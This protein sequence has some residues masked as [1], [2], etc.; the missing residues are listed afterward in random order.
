MKL[1]QLKNKGAKSA[2]TSPLS[3]P[4]ITMQN[5]IP[6]KEILQRKISL[7]KTVS[8]TKNPENINLK[9]FL[10][11]I[12]KPNSDKKI[13]QKRKKNIEQIRHLKSKGE[14]EK[15][16]ERKKLLPCACLSGTFKTR[17]QYQIIYYNGFIQIDVDDLADEDT[18]QQILEIIKSC[19]H[20]IVVFRS[21]SGKGIKAIGLG[22][23][24]PKH[25][26]GSFE[27]FKIWFA[28]KG[29]KIDNSVKDLARGCYMSHDPDL[30]IS[31]KVR[32]IE[33]KKIKPRFETLNQ[34]YGGSEKFSHRSKPIPKVHRIK[35]LKAIA[36]DWDGEQDR[37]GWLQICGAYLDACGGD[38]N[39][40]ASELEE[41]LPSCNKY[42]TAYTF[43]GD[44][45]IS[46]VPWETIWTH[47]PLNSELHP[48]PLNERYS[49]LYCTL[50]AEGKVPFSKHYDLLALKSDRGIATKIIHDYFGN[51]FRYCIDSKQFYVKEGHIWKPDNGL[52]FHVCSEL[53]DEA[54]AFAK[55]W[56]ESQESNSKSEANR[57]NEIYT[58]MLKKGKSLGSLPPLKRAIELASTN[59]EL[60][61]SNTDFDSNPYIIATKDVVIDLKTGEQL[62]NYSG[63]LRNALNVIFDPKAECE[64]WEKFLDD[65]MLGDKDMIDFLQ[66]LIGYALTGTVEDELVAFFTGTG[67]NGKSTFTETITYIMGDYSFISPPTLWAKAKGDQPKNDVADLF[68]KRFVLSSETEKGAVLADDQIKRLTNSD[69]SGR[70][71]Y[72]KTC[73]FTNTATIFIE[74]NSKPIIKDITDGTWRRLAV[75]NF[76]RQF[77]DSEQDTT[78][79]SRLR[80]EAPGILNWMI[81]GCIKWQS[82][83]L[84]KQPTKIRDA[85]AQ[86]RYQEDE[87]GSFIASCLVKSE[88]LRVDKKDVFLIYQEWATSQGI[89]HQK[90]QRQLS[91][92]LSEKGFVSKE[93]N[94][95]GY[96]LGYSLKEGNR[97]SSS[98]KII[99]GVFKKKKKIKS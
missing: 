98:S 75:V 82:K 47:I 46:A 79:K 60:Q 44:S 76:E 7:F 54:E 73:N 62:H 1:Q 91:K 52:L 34:N 89:N 50:K 66:R 29:I 33:P 48:L 22:L 86:Y 24:D 80:L 26:L 96:W 10:I 13:V 92:E 3:N 81:K 19:P 87:M 18:Y 65:I 27:A 78:L 28:D 15:V 4:K 9:S 32:P 63:Y 40:A 25:H 67:S 53:E 35:I 90:T 99:D 38:V 6:T 85:V 97:D 64:Q 74:G 23:K 94:S 72:D 11:R 59:P 55:K 88:S 17:S 84:K 41:Y 83:S 37:D 16:S 8:N 36:K 93:S 70:Q 20:I 5:F 39:L 49:Q 43:L 68:G 21:P 31:K 61:I 57:I 95:K 12:K 30:W 51:Y 2:K 45:T 71:L 14:K 58:E 69:L 56:V 77:K 42:D